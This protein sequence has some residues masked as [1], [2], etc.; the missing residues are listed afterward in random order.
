MK[1]AVVIPN[2]NG[3]DLLRQCIDSLLNKS[4]ASTIIVVENGS[5][6]ESDKILA[7]Y[8]KKIVVLKMF[9]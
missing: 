4:L 7:S 6:D 5:V 1:T 3:Q 8:G 9:A 2:R